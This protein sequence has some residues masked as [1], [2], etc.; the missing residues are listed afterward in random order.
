MWYSV[1]AQLRQRVGE[2]IVALL[3]MGTSP[4]RIAISIAVGTI[5]GVLPLLGSTTALCFVIAV[6]LRLNLVAMQ[7][8]NWLVAGPQLIMILPFIR[9]G[10]WL[11][12]APPL[13]LQ[14]N[15]TD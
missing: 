6:A 9:L 3:R 12:R 4:Q 5:I 1:R 11:Y 7:A 8:F 13:G 14:L 2:P 15:G 10:E